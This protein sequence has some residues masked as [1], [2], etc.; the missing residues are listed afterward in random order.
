MMSQL[1]I[2]RLAV[3]DCCLEKDGNKENAA[4]PE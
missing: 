4:R 2:A 1:C 3:M